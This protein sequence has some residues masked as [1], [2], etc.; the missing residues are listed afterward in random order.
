M[1]ILGWYGKSNCGDEAFKIAFRKL[2]P[3]AV[4]DFTCETTSGSNEYVLGGGDVIKPFYLD[5]LKDKT[6]SILGAG[7]GY[8]SEV[9]LLKGKNLKH[10]F[11]RN[12]SDVALAQAA[13]IKQAAY[14]PDLVF[15]LDAPQRTVTVGPK[16]RAIVIL[17]DAINPSA[18][19][20]DAAKLANAEYF[21]WELANA[22]SELSQ[23]YDFTFV[24]FSG[25]QY[26]N[27]HRCALDIAARM[28]PLSNESSIL[29]EAVSPRAAMGLIA[30]ADLV[31]TMKYHGVIFSTV[32]GVPFVNIGVSRKT[33]EFCR[34][35]GIGRLSV[36]EYAFTKDRFFEAVKAAETP[37]LDV[38]LM[39]IAKEKQRTLMDT[40]PKLFT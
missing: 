15:A 34:E 19:N 37:L 5:V 9:E 13:G 3:R 33:Q 24:P 32:G 1:N 20:K 6:F 18:G 8:E 14:C 39:G 4:L 16:K 38:R 27:D 23:W 2:F 35:A 12:H 21:K 11:L 29:A 28:S 25:H 17:S 30:C 36:P 26:D 31:I 7:L 40:L 10:V 22:L